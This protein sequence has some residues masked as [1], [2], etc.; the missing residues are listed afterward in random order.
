MRHLIRL[1]WL[2]VCL[3]A[4]SSTILFIIQRGFGGGHLKFDRALYL[5]GLPWNRISL[6]EYIVKYDWV[7]IVAI[8]WMI[9]IIV[10]ILIT[11]INR[12]IIK[13]K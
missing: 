5:L 2:L 6:P 7:H 3:G 9:N 1:L 11:I 4:L 8:P 13:G 12:G 10:V